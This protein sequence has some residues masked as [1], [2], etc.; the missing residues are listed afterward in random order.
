MLEVNIEKRLPG[1]TLDVS[2]SVGREILAVLGPSG[3]GKTMTLQ[4]IAGLLKPDEGYIRVNNR[5]LFDKSTGTNL[6]PQTR[7]VGFVFQNYALF[8]HLT[9]R[10]NISYGIRNRS[11]PDIL[12]RVTQLMKDMRITGLENRY[13]RQLS[14][15]QQQRVALA[16]AIAPQPEVL[17]LDEPFSALDSMV[18]ERLEVELLNLQKIYDGPIIF[19]T[20]N[21]S[22][23]Y[24]LASK[25]AI[26]DAGSVIQCDN[27]VKLVNSPASLTV[28]RLTGCK[29]IF[30]G[31]IS[32]TEGENV[33]IDVP[34]FG[35]FRTLLHHRDNSCLVKGL[36]VTFGI[37]SEH[38]LHAD[39]NT[40]NIV[41]GTVVA[42]M[43][44]ITSNRCVFHPLCNPETPLEAIFRSGTGN[45]VLDPGMQADFYFPPEYII[46]IGRFLNET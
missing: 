5:V 14:A 43:D 7:K 26:Y 40:E 6:S 11:K 19:V 8:P 21:L 10:D 45:G 4:S 36:Q 41:R 1:F 17:L 18:K 38:V 25:I 30:T 2:F 12:T 3:S 23:G 46:I 28:A 37:R 13:P 20:H 16:R 29:N 15:G 33:W 9:V 44:E 39:S 27:K 24:K 35:T 22:E 34:E 42:N 32:E 31:M